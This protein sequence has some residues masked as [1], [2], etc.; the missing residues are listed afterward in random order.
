MSIRTADFKKP[1]KASLSKIKHQ[2][3]Y[4]AEIYTQTVVVS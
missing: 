2:G 1:L 4:F 3:D